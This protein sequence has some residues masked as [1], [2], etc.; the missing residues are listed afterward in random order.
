MPRTEGLE[1]R[2]AL[3]ADIG[4][5]LNVNA[6]Y[7]HDP[8]WTDL[9]NLAGG[10]SQISGSGDGPIDGRRLPADQRTYLVRPDQLSRRQLR[11]QLHRH[12]NP[13]RQGYRRRSR[14]P[15]PSRAG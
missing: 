6:N 13:D 12:G 2:I 4:V 5:N 1:S 7:N 8:I 9:H 14:G 11:V 10:W 15:S 3:S